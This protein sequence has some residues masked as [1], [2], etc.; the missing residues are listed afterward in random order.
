[1][2]GNN[3]V[4]LSACLS[5]VCTIRP[6]RGFLQFSNSINPKVLLRYQGRLLSQFHS[7]REIVYRTSTL[8][9]WQASALICSQVFCIR[10]AFRSVPL[11]WQNVLLLL[12]VN[13]CMRTLTKFLSWTHPG[14]TSSFDLLFDFNPVSLRYLPAMQRDAVKEFSERRIPG[15]FFFDIDKVSDT[16]SPWP[17]M[18]PSPATFA[19]VS[20]FSLPL[21]CLMV[22]SLS[23]Q[24]CADFGI[25]RGSHVVVYDGKGVFSSPRA[26]YMFKAMGHPKVSILDGGFPRWASLALPV[27]SESKSVDAISANQA[28]YSC[29]IQKGTILDMAQVEANIASKE[30]QLI[31]G[32][33]KPRF[34]GEA[35]EPRP[36]ESGHIEG[37][38]SVPFLDV[39]KPDGSFKDEAELKQVFADAKVDLSQPCAVTCGSGVTACVVRAALE[40]VGVREAPLYDGAYTEWKTT[41]KPTYKGLDKSPYA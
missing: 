10:E 24:C 25:S 9:F 18:M 26:W 4:R 32:R 41:G 33:P 12:A 2:S 22:D 13:G 1:M 29:E 5:L 19:K 14:K 34:V 38:Y 35:P 40:V 20:S 21:Y 27:D 17:H 15:A 28:A 23:E 30:F 39:L 37:S 8:A 16:E 11:Q 31:D 7:R 6:A 36:I 3:L